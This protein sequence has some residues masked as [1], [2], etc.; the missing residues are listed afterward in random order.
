VSAVCRLETASA[1]FTAVWRRHL[2]ANPNKGYTR[3][4]RACMPACW[5]CLLSAVC[6][7]C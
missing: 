4:L 2:L 5:L 1:D 3:C 6:A 7:E